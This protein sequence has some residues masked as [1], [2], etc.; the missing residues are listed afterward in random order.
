MRCKPFFR[1]HPADACVEQEFYTAC[2]HVD[3]VSIA[4]GLK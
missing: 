2:F 3:A 4:S 1:L